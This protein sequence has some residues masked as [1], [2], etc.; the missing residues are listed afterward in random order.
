MQIFEREDYELFASPDTLCQ[1]AGVSRAN[2][3]V[4]V[5]KELVDNALDEAGSCE[6]DLSSGNGFSIIDQGEGIPG[7]DEAIA[8]FFSIRRPMQSSK[9]W[10]MP[11]R[12][13]LG[14]GLRVV[15]GAVLVS[16]GSL[17]VCT[18]GRRLKL[19]PCDSGETRVLSRDDWDGKGTHIDVELGDVFEVTRRAVVWPSV[20]ARF[21]VA[22]NSYKGATSP[23]WYDTD[24]FHSLCRAAKG[25]T[26]RELISRF[27][28]CTGRKSGI[29]AGQFL[30]K[31]ASELSREESEKL[32]LAAREG[33]KP[34]NPLRLGP[35]GRIST[36]PGAYGVAHGEIKLD[37]GRGNLSAVIPYIV[38]AWAAAADG[39]ETAIACVNRTPV[40]ADMSIVRQEEKTVIGI[41]GCGLALGVKVGRNPLSL[42]LNI[43]TPYMPV[44]SDGKAPDLSRYKAAIQAAVET[45]ARRSKRAT[46][47][48][49]EKKPSK[50]SVILR[51]LSA[52][53]AKAS[54]NG[55]TRFSQRQLYYAIRPRLLEIFGNSQSD[56]NASNSDYNYFCTVLTK[57]EI[58]HGA[59]PNLYRDIRGTLY[60]PHERREIP[61]GTLAVEEYKRP[62]WTFNKILY[63]EKEGLF[64]ILLNANW[65]E[66]HDCALMTS[67]GYSSR[68]ARDILD[69]L[70]TTGEAI[71]FYCVHDADAAGTMIY[72]TLQNATRARPGRQFTITNLGLDPWEAL[73]M[74]LETETFKRRGK[75]Q[76]PV[77][78][79]LK[80]RDNGRWVKWLQTRRAELNAMDSPT[81]LRWLDQ[82]MEEHA[83]EKIVP[84]QEVL[85]HTFESSTRDQVKK[86]ITE[87]LLRA[88]NLDGRIVQRMN[89][90]APEIQN[91]LLNLPQLVE[92]ELATSDAD[93]WKSP[94]ERA[95][96]ILARTEVAVQ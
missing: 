53:T 74:G 4:V 61:L 21:S 71:R 33:A 39:D 5:L 54:G 47:A 23:H 92:E 41:F 37:P 31:A 35:V 77:A 82:K 30:N 34:V 36:L 66:R 88:G 60:H 28:G 6:F 83:S 69:L 10:R 93:L 12:G 18:R 42:I 65:P 7:D 25:A 20:A 90:L 72:Q 32:L 22:E 79:Y 89:E 27:D 81:F 51:S 91:Q 67:K 57:Y 16:N 85:H 68:A 50:K 80:G 3:P 96:E 94:V 29:I 19:Q 56:E 17:T 26:V 55:A 40:V 13:A 46:A 95:A 64:P 14:N 59:I 70:S 11:A 8:R 44:T 1:K 75:A 43:Q 9:L 73:E 62:A 49:D 86:L 24:S 58:E 76:A 52:A 45:A 87:E 63:C 2:L 48:T 78:D 84:P 38:E 15:A